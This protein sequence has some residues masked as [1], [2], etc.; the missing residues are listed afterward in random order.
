MC[1]CE[2]LLVIRVVTAVVLLISDVTAF[3]CVCCGSE[4]R[5][6][7]REGEKSRRR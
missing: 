5:N 2:S 7:G 3:V 1:V 4:G 6:R